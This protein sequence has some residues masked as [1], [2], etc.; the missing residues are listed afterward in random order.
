MPPVRRVRRVIAAL[1]GALIA[2]AATGCGGA[3]VRPPAPANTSATPAPLGPPPPE[4]WF[5]D[6]PEAFAECAA[7]AAAPAV[8]L[9]APYQRCDGAEEAWASPPG[10]NELHF[11]YRAFSAAVTAARRARDPDLCCYLV[12]EF[13]HFGGD[14]GS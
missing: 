4:P 1:I 10:G 9:P 8:P 6:Q 12:W 13:P 2:V 11:H 14:D 5:H 3:R 7:P